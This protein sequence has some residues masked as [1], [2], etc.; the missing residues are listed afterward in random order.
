MG[1]EE[2]KRVF[3]IFNTSAR[4]LNKWRDDGRRGE[5]GKAIFRDEGMCGWSEEHVESMIYRLT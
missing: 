1:G 4:R 3:P 5:D 2:Q